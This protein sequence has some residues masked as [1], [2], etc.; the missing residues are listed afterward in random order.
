MFG[1]FLNTPR[2]SQT[3][4]K[5]TAWDSHTFNTLCCSRKQVFQYTV[6]QDKT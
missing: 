6:A 2:M 5:L 3:I 4:T 1:L